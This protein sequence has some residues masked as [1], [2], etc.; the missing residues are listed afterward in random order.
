MRLVDI[1]DLRVDFAQH[2]GVIQAVRGVSLHVDEGESLGIVG[3]SGSGKSVTFL[4]LLRLLAGTARVSAEA[5]V[6]DG[7]DVL[8]A[9][10]RTLSAMRGRSAAMVFQDPMTAFDP[11]FTIGH[12]IVETIRTHRKVSRRDAMAEA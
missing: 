12:Q 9:D 8:G 5:M 4:A 11:V 7:V 6:L 1:K 3:E 2:G 10:R